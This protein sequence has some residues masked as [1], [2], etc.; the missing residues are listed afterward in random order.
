[1]DGVLVPYLPTGLWVLATAAIAAIAIAVLGLYIYLRKRMGAALKDAGDAANLAAQKE[2]LEKDVEELRLWIETHKNELLQLKAEREEQERERA[3]LDQLIRDFADQDQKNQHL[4]NEVG[5]LENDRHILSQTCDNLK[6]QK[7]E[8]TR[9][10]TELELKRAEKGDLEKVLSEL[11]DRVQE[12]KVA[13]TQLAEV[14]VKVAAFAA[15]KAVLGQAIKSLTQEEDT[16]RKRFEDLKL[17]YEANLNEHNR[18][19]DQ[20]SNGQREVAQ[21]ENERQILTNRCQDLT[22]ELDNQQGIQK[23]KRG[24]IED[25]EKRLVELRNQIGDVQIVESRL[26]GLQTTISAFSAEKEALDRTIKGLRQNEVGIQKRINELK[27][28]HTKEMSSLQAVSKTLRVAEQSLSDVDKK[29]EDLDMT[30]NKMSIRK[31]LLLKEI[32]DLSAKSGSE[33]EKEDGATDS[34]DDLLIKEPAC[35]DRSAFSGPI[36]LKDETDALNRLKRKLRDE[37]LLFHP[38]VIDAFHTSLKCQ[39]ISPLTVLAGV[40][41]TGKTLLPVKYSEYMGI[42]L[43]VMAVQPRWDSPQDMFGFYNYLEK[44]YKAT[45][46]ARA[47][48]RM[49]EYNYP[50]HK[51]DWSWCKDR[52]LLVLLDEMNLART[53]YYFSEFLSRLELRPKVDYPQKSYDRSKAEIELDVGPGK[54]SF[55][56]W[57]PENVLFVGTMN[58]DETTQTLSDKVLDRANLLRFGKPDEQAGAD[59]KRRHTEEQLS[60][61]LSFEQ[62]DSWLRPTDQGT[63]WYQDVKNWTKRLNQGLDLVGRPFGFR[64]PL[65][66]EYYVANYP[67]TDNNGR[68]KLAFA[69]LVEQKII[70]KIRGID[71]GWKAAR[72]CLDE[73]QRVIEELED[74]DLA[75]AFKKARDESAEM[76]AFQWRGV[77]RNEGENLL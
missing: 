77:T 60:E 66:I 12:A 49:D 70:P 11:K 61:F 4:R 36:Q 31:E 32:E 48:V 58:E 1:M 33:A 17:T 76:G 15:E 68:Y 27:A 2:R 24:E 75:E 16:I 42:H 43:L 35:L 71:M 18:V 67:E 34:Y 59:D 3:K 65:I 64:V 69:D 72:Q 23:K 74:N 39:K 56:V 53:E 29:K 73:V 9:Q 8:L 14:Q 22:T 20:V 5:Q 40:S 51:E 47:L 55:R 30:L 46:L 21:L 13:Q 7:D 38:R 25:L 45:E 28:T 52:L 19:K 62:W 44:R 57:V 41:G 10:I 37:G 50:D 54:Q 6:T 26:A 63:E